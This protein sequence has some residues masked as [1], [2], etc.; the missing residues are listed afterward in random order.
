MCVWCTCRSAYTEAFIDTITAPVSEKF[1]VS[2]QQRVRRVSAP[3]NPPYHKSGS[4]GNTSLDQVFEEGGIGGGGDKG[5]ILSP[6]S[7]DNTMPMSYS[8]DDLQQ[9][10][11]D[12]DALGPSKWKKYGIAAR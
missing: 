3:I 11:E 10:Q 12:A 4:S 5:G 6:V 2:D 7:I 1:G 9:L 8:A